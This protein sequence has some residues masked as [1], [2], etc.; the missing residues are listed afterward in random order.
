MESAWEE[1]GKQA[2]K[3]DQEILKRELEIIMSKQLTD[4]WKDKLLEIK[5][6]ELAVLSTAS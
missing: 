5:E 6:R 4:I 1:F 2:F 3:K